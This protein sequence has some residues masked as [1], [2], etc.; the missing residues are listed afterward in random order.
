[1]IKNESQLT[2]AKQE[3]EELL[4]AL[5]Q[6]KGEEL[7]D[8]MAKSSILLPFERLEFG[9]RRIRE[10]KKPAIPVFHKRKPS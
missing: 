3:M 5:Y 1:M 8:R 2:R 9:N 4:D 7:T 6:I 10:T